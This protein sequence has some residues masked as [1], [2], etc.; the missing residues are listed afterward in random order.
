[1]GAG[2]ALSITINVPHA[3]V[4]EW[5]INDNGTVCTTLNVKFVSDNGKF[6]YYFSSAVQL[7]I[8]TL[9]L[10]VTSILIIKKIKRT[11]D[12]IEE[13]TEISVNRNKEHKIT[14]KLLAVILVFTVK[15]I[16][17]FTLKFF[18]M[19]SGNVLFASNYDLL[20]VLNCGV[21]I[22]IYG[23]YDENFRKNLLSRY[24]DDKK[25]TVYTQ[26]TKSH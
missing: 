2:L 16:L 24:K 23:M 4:Y 20:V 22:I 14:K 6:L 21:N 1:M 3:W 19:S 7:I 11:N 12:T 5:H 9:T 10:I 17:I 8:P 15:S 18:H 25:T 26:V 13:L